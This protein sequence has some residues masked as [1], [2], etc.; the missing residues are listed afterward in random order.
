MKIGRVVEKLEAAVRKR[1][2]RIKDVQAGNSSVKH[3]GD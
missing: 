2:W 1:K 3:T